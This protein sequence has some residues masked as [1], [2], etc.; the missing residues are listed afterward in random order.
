MQEPRIGVL[1]SGC[2]IHVCGGD[3]W[4]PYTIGRQA[5]SLV[6]QRRKKVGF[7]DSRCSFHVST[8]IGG[9]NVS[10]AAP[11]AKILKI[12]HLHPLWR[13]KLCFC[14]T[15]RKISEIIFTPGDDPFTSPYI[16]PQTLLL[17]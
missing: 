16:G 13:D 8:L 6:G 11:G 15:K 5:L 4:P 1:D 3:T 10:V 7:L 17:E 14:P 2:A 12:F 9:Q